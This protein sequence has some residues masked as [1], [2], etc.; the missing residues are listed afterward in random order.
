MIPNADTVGA[1]LS[2]LAPKLRRYKALPVDGHH[3]GYRSLW[4]EAFPGSGLGEGWYGVALMTQLAGLSNAAAASHVCWSD[5]RPR[6]RPASTR[7]TTSHASSSEQASNWCAGRQL[8]S[9]RYTA[10]K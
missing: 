5:G 9:R 8:E 3:P 6:R 7:P 1:L 4:G 2:P 10:V